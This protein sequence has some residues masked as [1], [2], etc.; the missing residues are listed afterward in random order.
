M[1]RELR[2]AGFL[3]FMI[4]MRDPHPRSTSARAAPSTFCPSQ[5]ASMPMVTSDPSIAQT[6]RSELH[7][8]AV[9]IVGT[10]TGLV[11]RTK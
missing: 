10:T 1:V 9:R 7:L 6:L 4:T 3:A 2:A 11:N 5:T 8:D